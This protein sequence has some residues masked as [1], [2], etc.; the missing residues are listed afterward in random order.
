MKKINII[1]FIFIILSKNL[2][3]S[4][5]LIGVRGDISRA[6]YSFETPSAKSIV[7]WDNLTQR[8]FGVDVGIK[9]N[10]YFNIYYNYT[11]TSG[12]GNGIDD[13]LTNWNFNNFGRFS[14]HRAKS[15][16]NDN[17][18]GINISLFN[19]D[20]IKFSGRI[21]YI[22]KNATMRFFNGEKMAVNK[23]NIGLIEANPDVMMQKS[24][25]VFTSPSIG[26]KIDKILSDDDIFSIIF[27]YYPAI[28]YRAK[29]FLPTIEGPDSRFNLRNN[30]KNNRGFFLH[31]E[32]NFRLIGDLWFKIYTN[33]ERIKINK[34]RQAGFDKVSIDIFNPFILYPNSLDAKS[35][36]HVKW[37]N[38][39]GGVGFN[40]IF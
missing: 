18:S 30:I 14:I 40:Y 25:A 7:K 17:K 2:Y 1:I 3:A 10:D 8:G 6:N 35:L 19:N 24:F 21:G 33:Y 4:N 36:G 12:S 38:I 28:Q 31:G 37:E 22:Y 20:A 29:Q 11:K 39:S 15:I 13:N 34:L 5:L 27:D 26:I 9:F 16:I 32:N 23:N